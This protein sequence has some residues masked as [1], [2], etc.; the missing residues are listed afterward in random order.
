MTAPSW[1]LPVLHRPGSDHIVRDRS[2]A[3]ECLAPDRCHVHARFRQDQDTVDALRREDVDDHEVPHW[4]EVAVTGEAGDVVAR[5]RKQLHVRRERHA[6][7]D[8]PGPDC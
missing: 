5:V 4:S 8:T 7:P 1:M 3:I 6:H 2:G